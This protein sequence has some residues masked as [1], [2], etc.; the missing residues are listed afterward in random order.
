M[1]T[2]MPHHL[3]LEVD[4]CLKLNLNNR[5]F[6]MLAEFIDSYENSRQIA[7]ELMVKSPEEVLAILNRFILTSGNDG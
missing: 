6:E 1:T 2:P 4:R 3:A 7:N 5:Q